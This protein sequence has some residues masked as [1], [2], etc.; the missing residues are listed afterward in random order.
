S[1]AEGEAALKTSLDDADSLLSLSPETKRDRAM[2][3]LLLATIEQARMFGKAQVENDAVIIT[4]ETKEAR[5]CQSEVR[6]QRS[7]GSKSAEPFTLLGQ[8]AVE[9]ASAARA[10]LAVRKLKSSSPSGC[11]SGSTASPS[12]QVIRLKS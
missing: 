7:N 12:A 9:A 8:R 3:K 10:R 2:A 5:G 1:K 11:N 4:V 6:D